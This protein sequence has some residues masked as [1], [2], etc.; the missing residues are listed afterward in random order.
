MFVLAMAAVNAELRAI[1]LYNRAKF[2]SFCA[3]LLIPYMTAIL[4]TLANSVKNSAHRI[5]EF[6]LGMLNSFF[7]NSNFVC[8]IRILFKLLYRLLVVF[9]YIM[10]SAS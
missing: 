7:S 5:A 6:W 10:Y 9:R 1:L 4:R 2:Y 3:A 8:K